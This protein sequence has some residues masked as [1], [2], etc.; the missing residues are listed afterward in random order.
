[1]T[2]YPAAFWSALITSAVDTAPSLRTKSAF[3]GLWPASLGT[4]SGPRRFFHFFWSIPFSNHN[5]AR[6]LVYRLLHRRR[7]LNRELYAFRMSFSLP[8]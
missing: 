7:L 5:V 2:L 6:S 8:F 4:R 1:M 3:A